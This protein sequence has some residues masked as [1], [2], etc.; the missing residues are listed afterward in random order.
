MIYMILVFSELMKEQ[1]FIVSNILL[2]SL[3]FWMNYV[4]MDDKYDISFL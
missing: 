1:F 4:C 3:I 2:H